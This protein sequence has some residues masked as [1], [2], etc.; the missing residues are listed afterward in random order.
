[1]KEEY[2]FWGGGESSRRLLMKVDPC[3]GRAGARGDACLGGVSETDRD[4]DLDL[5]LDLDRDLDAG[6]RE[7]FRRSG[8][9]S[10]RP[11]L[12]SGL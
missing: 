5:D 10:R 1:M 7:E 11:L 3:E 4:R 9:D 2:C 6:E 12:S 8:V